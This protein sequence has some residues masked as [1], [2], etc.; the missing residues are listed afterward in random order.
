[1]CKISSASVE[2]VATV[3]WLDLGAF[4]SDGGGSGK[5]EAESSDKVTMISEEAMG[6][7][8]L[9]IWIEAIRDSGNMSMMVVSAIRT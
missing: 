5:A 2:M 4:V 8:S 1:M 9:S 6:Y 3:G 7:K